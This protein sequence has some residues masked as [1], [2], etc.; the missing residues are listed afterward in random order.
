MTTAYKNLITT[1]VLIVPKRIQLDHPGRPRDEWTWPPGDTHFA[2]HGEWY[3]YQRRGRDA[4]MRA[5]QKEADFKDEPPYMGPS[6]LHTLLDIGAH[7]G[8]W[9]LDLAGRFTK[10]IAWE[11]EHWATLSRNAAWL[12]TNNVEV[13]PHAVSDRSAEVAFWSRADNTGDSGIDLGQA[14]EA[15]VKRMIMTRVIDQELEGYTGYVDAVKIDVQGHEYWVLAGMTKTIEKHQPVICVE[16]ND[17]NPAAETL[18]KSW[19]YAVE[20]RVGKDWIWM[21][22]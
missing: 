8:T 11:P 15:R 10:V 19:G 12:N 16:L 22:K 1:G 9:S 13:R 6:P 18:L 3:E 14:T 5:V 20:E 7:A 2:E 17:G 21:P 4:F